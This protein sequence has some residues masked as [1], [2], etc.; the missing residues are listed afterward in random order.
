MCPESARSVLSG[1]VGVGG[2]G[3]EGGGSWVFRCVGMAGTLP[4]LL[5]QRERGRGERR[6]RE[7]E[8][9]ERLCVLRDRQTVCLVERERVRE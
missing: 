9:S 2:G 5:L 7:R 4:W 1:A 8:C 6:E 3:G